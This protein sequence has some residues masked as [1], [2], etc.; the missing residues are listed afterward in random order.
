MINDLVFRTQRGKQFSQRN[1]RRAFKR[2]LV[3]AGLPDVSLH[4]LRHTA[5]TL[6]L[7]QGIHPKIVQERLGHAN[8]SM[9][10]DTYSA[11]LPRMGRDAAD[12]LDALLA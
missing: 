6:L 1:V 2:I 10:L 9:T 7:V 11:Y 5:A 12:K 4:A 3:V 8:I